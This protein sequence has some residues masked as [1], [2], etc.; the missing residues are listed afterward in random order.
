LD[1]NGKYHEVKLFFDPVDAAQEDLK[2][3]SSQNAR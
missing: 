1:K 2:N 3:L